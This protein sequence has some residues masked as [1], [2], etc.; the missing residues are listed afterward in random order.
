[1]SKSQIGVFGLG[2]MG[3]NLVLNIADHGYTVSVYNRSP[4]KTKELLKEA[5]EKNISGWYSVE[6]FV[7]SLEEPRKIIL[8]VKAGEAVDAAVKQLVPYLSKGDVL[9]DGGNSYYV[10][11]I[12]RSEELAAQG[13]NFI[14]SGISGGEEGARQGPA[15]M[16]GGNEA[17]YKLIEPILTDISA[18][19]EGETCCNFIGNDGAG[20][21]VKMVHN[22]IEY[23]D[24][25]LICE[26]YFLLKKVL[27]MSV[28][29]LHETFTEW[30]KGELNSFLIDITADIFK[31]TDPDSGKY[32][33]DIILDVAGQKGTGKWTSQIALD[34][35]VAVPTITEAVFAR[36]ISTLKEERVAASRIL[37]GPLNI[38]DKT[39]CFAESVRRALYA[40][41]ICSYAQG[42]ALMSSASH[43]HGWS[44]N[45]GNIAMLFRG[46]C[47]IRAQFLNRIKDAYKK[48]PKLSNLLLDDYFKEIVGSYQHELRDVVITAVEFGLPVPGLASALAYYDSYRSAELPLNLLQ[49]QRDYFGAHTYQRVDK[50]G[51]FHSEW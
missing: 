3:K 36:Y 45:L 27:H 30:N 35:G 31:K 51:I 50:E 47:I 1:M 38:E 42:F 11:T 2:V 33:V 14:G 43:K 5:G 20:H 8:M 6:E 4:E 48:N 39:K 34:L 18:K 29:E 28:P 49:A 32:L 9:I 21:F 24:M 46:G 25:Q 37:K 23:A 44:L 15:I 22:G 16:P 13:F 17:A 26:A 40:G 7:Q 10:D 41:K 12:R 19:V